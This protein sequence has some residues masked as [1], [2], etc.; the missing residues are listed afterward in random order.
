MWLLLLLLLLLLTPNT[1][2]NSRHWAHVSPN[3]LSHAQTRFLCINLV[4][5]VACIAGTKPYL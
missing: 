2:S 5:E 3:P 4:T 1:A